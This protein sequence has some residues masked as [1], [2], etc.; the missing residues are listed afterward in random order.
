L[1]HEFSNT[2]ELEEC[3]ATTYF[4]KIFTNWAC[5]IGNC[6]KYFTIFFIYIETINGATLHDPILN[7]LTQKMYLFTYLQL[8][9]AW[10]C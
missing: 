2:N 5:I 9:G 8:F 4:L 3:L 7:Y 10:H 6:I 1:Q